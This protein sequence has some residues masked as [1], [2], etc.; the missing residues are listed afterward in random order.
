MMYNE[1]WG[2]YFPMSIAPFG[3]NET[4]G[5]LYYPQTKEEIIDRDGKWQDND[6]SLKHTGPFYNPKDNIS[7]YQDETER[8]KLLDGILK[9]EKTGKPFKIA[10]Q[11]LAFYLEQSIPIPRRHYD[12]RFLDRFHRRNRFVLYE[13]ECMCE[14]SGH[15]HE[16]KCRVRFETTYA[17]DRPEKVYCEDCYQ[18]AVI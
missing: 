8:T 11:E 4:M 6:Y 12:T 9:C 2:Q 15:D 1:E 18:K 5:M 7:S 10:S 14:Q 13:R 17:P 16:G 3:Y